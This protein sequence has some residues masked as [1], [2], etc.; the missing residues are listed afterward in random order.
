MNN[1]T[2]FQDGN[3][4][5]TYGGHVSKRCPDDLLRRYNLLVDE[6]RMSWTEHHRLLRLLG[7]GGQGVV[8]LTQRRGTDG[9]TLPV[10]L[11]IF[12]PERATK[13]KLR[14]RRSDGPD[15]PRRRS[16][17]AD[18]AGQLARRA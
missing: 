9:F 13:T 16:G 11:K 15:G 6:Q 7:S 3:A 10:A 8:Y 5:L 18:P 12:S 17:R 14:L 4:T 1:T 2:T